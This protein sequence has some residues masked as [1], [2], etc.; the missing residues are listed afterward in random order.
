MLT[1]LK[2]EKPSHIQSE[3]SK[4]QQ[5]SIL[6]VSKNAKFCSILEDKKFTQYYIAE[7]FPT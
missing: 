4:N 1:I 6:I 3:I 5:S 7:F 2:L